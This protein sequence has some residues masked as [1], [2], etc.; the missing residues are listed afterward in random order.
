MSE[1]CEKRVKLASEYVEVTKDWQIHD[2]A[3]ML[4]IAASTLI[5]VSKDIRGL[6]SKTTREKPKKGM[7]DVLRKSSVRA[8]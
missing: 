3:K 1:F 2:Y 7:I 5:K 6:K 4:K 8:R